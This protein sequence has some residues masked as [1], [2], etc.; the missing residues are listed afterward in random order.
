MRIAAKLKN[1]GKRSEVKQSSY[2]AA[3]VEGLL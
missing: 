1:T 3:G 2:V